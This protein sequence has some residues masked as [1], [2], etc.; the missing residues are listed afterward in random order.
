VRVLVLASGSE[1]NATLV[2]SRGTRVLIDA[3]IGP[4]AL[5]CALE[6]ARLEVRLDAVV[7]THAHAD[8]F[9]FARKYAKKTRVPVYLTEATARAHDLPLA[10]RFVR[11]A[12]REPFAIGEL[13]IS[14]VPVPHDV[15]QIAVRI[16]D[17]QR[18]VA[19]ATDVG[20]V[21]GRLAD[22]VAGC[23]VLLLESNHD[24]EMLERGP[25][26]AFLKRR[27]ASSGGHL[28]NAQASELLARLSSRARAVVLMH[29]SRTNNMVDLA[30]TCARDALAGRRVHL[31]AAPAREL[32]M[33]D[34][35]S[36][37]PPPLPGAPPRAERRRPQ[38]L[39]GQLSFW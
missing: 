4:F 18:S 9:G 35:E 12:P 30:M 22:H 38:V 33:L 14:P 17:G 19:I 21:T 3:G 1:G 26:P 16:S 13:S 7:V 25:Y 15:P 6:R 20:E 37:A 34:T 31:F 11:F 5:R 10:G 28:S 8:H 23:D 27:V 29:L 24:P 36:P 32:L 39:P 2:E